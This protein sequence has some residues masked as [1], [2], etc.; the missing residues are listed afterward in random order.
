[1][2]IQVQETM[3][4]WAYSSKNSNTNN[5]IQ[6][7]SK[8][9]GTQPTNYTP[10]TRIFTPTLYQ[11]HQVSHQ[12]YYHKY[13]IRYLKELNIQQNQQKSRIFVMDILIIFNQV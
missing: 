2:H 12:P 11:L 13:L 9:I 5:P 6:N 7:S 1:M 8:N 4:T 3:P 10:Q